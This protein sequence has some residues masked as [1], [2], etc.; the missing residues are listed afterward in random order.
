MGVSRVRAL[1]V[2]CRSAAVP[3]IG[4]DEDAQRC[5]S[6]VTGVAASQPAS[7]LSESEMFATAGH[8]ALQVGSADCVATVALIKS[9]I[10]HAVLQT[11]VLKSHSSRTER[12]DWRSC[13]SV[14]RSSG[15]P[16][17]SRNHSLVDP[18]ANFRDP[19]VSMV[20]QYI[21]TP[22]R[23]NNART[24]WLSLL[25]AKSALPTTIKSTRPHARYCTRSKRNPP[26]TRV[27]VLQ[28]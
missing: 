13:R 20:C 26:R 4:L 1:N 9:A 22:D 16:N 6:R 19:G 3:P 11:H 5:Q 21:C 23:T 7:A 18:R 27:L 24:C 10:H 8:D 28:Q 14:G 25:E 17:G 2:A 12:P 15:L